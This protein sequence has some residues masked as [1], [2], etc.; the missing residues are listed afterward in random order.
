MVLRAQNI[1]PSILTWARETAGLS[2]DEAATRIHLSPSQKS[3]KGEKL[4]AFEEGKMKPTRKQLLDLAR[5]YHRPLTVFYLN[6]PP[7]TFDRG[8]DF[9]VLSD[10]V[11]PK[12]NALFDALLRDVHARQGLVKDILEDDEDVERLGFVGSSKIDKSVRVMAG[13]IKE[14]LGISGDNWTKGCANS[15]G[16]FVY[17]RNKVENLGVFVPLIGD[18]GSHH[19]DISDKVFRGFVVADH[20]AP[21]IVINDNDQGGRASWSFTLA[22]ELV[23]LF[24]GTTGVSALPTPETPR[25]QS[26]Q[27]EQFCTDV[28]NELLLP[29]GALEGISKM[30]SKEVAEGVIAKLAEARNLGELMIAYRL[31]RM[32]CISRDIYSRLCE[33]YVEQ[34]RRERQQN[35]EQTKE[36]D[37]WPIYYATRKHR[38]GRALLNLVGRTLRENR[39]THTTAA[40]ILGVNPNCVE[41]LLDLVEGINRSHLPKKISEK[42]E[43]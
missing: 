10:L 22:H 9:R 14:R 20:L 2:A 40:Q 23:H 13:Q 19:S 6:K 7:R 12:E 39:L 8:E 3:S 42:K 15:D 35:K 4:K 5:V 21:F 17:L 16:L 31:R 28:A 27:V 29:A 33:S 43:I 11:S 34:I 36:S 1:N 18:L 24:L 32:N 25:T 38:L 37:G 41:P 26:E 30:T